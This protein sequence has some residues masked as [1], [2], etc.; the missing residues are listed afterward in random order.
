MNLLSGLKYLST[1]L[2]PSATSRRLPESTLGLCGP[3]SVD[4]LI[5]AEQPLVVEKFG[6]PKTWSAVVS[7][8]LYSRTRE[9]ESDNAGGNFLHPARV[10]VAIELCA[11]GRGRGQGYTRYTEVLVALHH[12]GQRRDSAAPQLR[13]E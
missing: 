12:V 6:S 10:G 9:L 8:G 3:H 4:A 13:I 2:K 1:R 11:Q 7:P 5:P